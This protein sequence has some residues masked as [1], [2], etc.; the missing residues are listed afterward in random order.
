MLD[1]SEKILAYQNQSLWFQLACI[2][3]E[4]HRALN[5]HQKQNAKLCDDAVARGIEL[6]NCTLSNPK[7]SPSRRQEIGRSKE[8]FL[9]YLY[10]DNQYQSTSESIDRYFHSYSLLAQKERNLA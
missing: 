2:A 4:V 1:T 8:V 10:G 9:D 5:W 6:F 3:S 7:I